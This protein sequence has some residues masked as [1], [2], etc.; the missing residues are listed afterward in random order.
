MWFKLSWENESGTHSSDESCTCHRFSFIDF[1]LIIKCCVTLSFNILLPISTYALTPLV[2]VSECAINIAYSLQRS[3]HEWAS[4]TLKKNR[5]MSNN[6][7][8]KNSPDI[9]LGARSLY[10]DSS[11]LIKTISLEERGIC[12][13]KNNYHIGY[14]PPGDYNFHWIA[15]Q[16][17]IKDVRG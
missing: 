6:V 17:M 10:L 7:H 3:L 12:R 5:G 2:L 1:Y 14:W 15:M 4:A 13:R 16:L 8:A 9:T 11:A